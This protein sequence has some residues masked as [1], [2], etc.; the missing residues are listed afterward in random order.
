MLSNYSGEGSFVTIKTSSTRPRRGALIPI[1]LR[2]TEVSNIS[3]LDSSTFG[4]HQ[5]GLLAEGSTDNRSVVPPPGLL[6]PGPLVLIV[7]L[8]CVLLSDDCERDPSQ[9]G[10]TAAGDITFKL[11]EQDNQIKL[12]MA[13][14]GAGGG[15]SKLWQLHFSLCRHS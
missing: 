11:V 8:A 2:P 6:D 13:G 5:I 14:G 4:K 3:P 15:W 10:Q 1:S 7:C 12:N 9:C